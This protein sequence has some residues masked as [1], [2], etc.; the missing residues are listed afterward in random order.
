MA[1]EWGV[2]TPGGQVRLSDL[3]LE[4][5]IELEEQ[6]DTEWWSICAHPFRRASIAQASYRAACT[7]IGCEPELLRLNDLVEGKIFVQVEDDLPE[8]YEEGI[9]KAEEEAPTPG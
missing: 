7:H 5:A 4:E 1:S 2:N 3:T 9:P 8:V 6:T